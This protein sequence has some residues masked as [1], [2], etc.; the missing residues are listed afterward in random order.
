MLLTLPQLQKE[1]QKILRYPQYYPPFFLWA[2]CSRHRLM[3]PTVM[4]LQLLFVDDNSGCSRSSLRV[5][6]IVPQHP[7]CLPLS[8]TLLATQRLWS[9]LSLIGDMYFT[10]HALSTPPEGP[11]TKASCRNCANSLRAVGNKKISL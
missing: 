4:G 2:P 7:F 10:F 11:N 6:S 9:V 5:S 1:L 8:G 3:H